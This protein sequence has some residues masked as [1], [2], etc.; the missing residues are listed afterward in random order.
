MKR[1]YGMSSGEHLLIFGASARA[2]AFSALR[3]G[4]R[5]WCAD[6]FGD[7]DLQACCPVRVLAPGSYPR[8]FIQAA[9]EGPPGPWMYTGGLENRRS[10]VRRISATRPL[11]GNSAAVLRRARSPRTLQTACREAGISC[12][13]I[14]WP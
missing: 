6:L 11:W 2:A 5:P 13:A 7:A 9:S 14:D 4:L 12:P 3:A 1:E 10:V 8:G